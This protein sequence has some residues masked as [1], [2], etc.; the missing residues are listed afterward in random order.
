MLKQS[1]KTE[2]KFITNLVLR[3]LWSYLAHKKRP[4]EG[5]QSQAGYIS[6]VK[7]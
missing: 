6:N 4:F 3:I 1:T 2:A 7:Y 5:P